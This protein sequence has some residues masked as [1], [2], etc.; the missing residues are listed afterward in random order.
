MIA[1]FGLRGVSS[2]ARR[3]AECGVISGAS[4][5]KIALDTPHHGAFDG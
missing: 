5:P 1:D 3:D 2:V 4:V